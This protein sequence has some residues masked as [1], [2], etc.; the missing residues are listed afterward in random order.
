RIADVR[1]ERK[2]FDRGLEAA[3]SGLKVND[4]N[5]NCLNARGLAWYGKKELTR[6]CDD[7]GG[8]IKSDPNHP[9]AYFNRANANS[10]L[11]KWPEALADVD[12]AVRIT[13][14]NADAWLLRG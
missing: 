14:R 1:N 5:S 4:K 7:F 13:P 3:N 8:A 6:A 12:E 2:E 9:N 10:D 11:E